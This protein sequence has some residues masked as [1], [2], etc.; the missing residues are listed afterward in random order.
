MRDSFSLQPNITPSIA[1]H[2]ML[3]SNLLKNGLFLLAG[4]HGVF[5]ARMETASG[6]RINKIR[7]VARNYP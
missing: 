7:Y 5:A 2:K 1:C 4:F 3:G 6:W